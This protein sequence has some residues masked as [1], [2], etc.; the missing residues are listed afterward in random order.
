[1]GYLDENST[2]SS[3]RLYILLIIIGILL[4]IASTCVYIVIS[5]WKPKIDIDWSG[6]AL[7][8]GGLAAFS[9]SILFTKSLQKKHEVD[10]AKKE[11][12]IES[13]KLFDK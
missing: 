13:S 9:S 12:E 3:M 4:L 6:L 5:L 7:W 2:K 10:K 11:L 8:I 1:M